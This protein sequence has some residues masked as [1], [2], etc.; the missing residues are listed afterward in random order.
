MRLPPLHVLATDEE[1]ARPDFSGLALSMQNVCG[2][3]LALHLRLKEREAR[4]L[5]D[6]A[7]EHARRASET[8]G[9]CVVNGRV[10]VA[11]ASGAQA[12][13]LGRGALPVPAARQLLPARVA[14]GASVHTSEEAIRVAFEGADY[15]LL[16]T[17]FPS[18]SHP[19]GPTGGLPL[20]R[21][22]RDAVTPLVAV[23]GITVDTVADVVA[24]GARGVAV[25]GA[26]WRHPSPLDAALELSAELTAALSPAARSDHG[27]AGR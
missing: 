25:I 21:Q 23:G 24:A 1:V 19:G 26:V 20:V 22:C 27:G 18:A 4:R 10:D 15:L 7:S 5:F 6:L 13:Q 2:P 3:Q 12:V 14:V 8:G 9:W 17:I 16:G 11:L